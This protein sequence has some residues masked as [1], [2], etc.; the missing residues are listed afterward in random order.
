MAAQ[1]MVLQ[2]NY[3]HEWISYRGVICGT[4]PH[5]AISTLARPLPGDLKAI[6]LYKIPFKLPGMEH[7]KRGSDRAMTIT[8]YGCNRKDIDELVDFIVDAKSLLRENIALPSS[9][10]SCKPDPLPARQQANC[11]FPI[12]L[13]SPPCHYCVTP[14]LMLHLTRIVGT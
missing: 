4:I 12:S 14:V 10:L 2:H 9:H 1:Q 6:S 3:Q 11:L 13:S 8:K 7:Q 5:T